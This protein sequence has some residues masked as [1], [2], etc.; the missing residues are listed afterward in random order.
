L[1]R[2]STNSHPGTAGSGT[3]VR[4]SP[5]EKLLYSR[6]DAAEALSISLRMIDYAL[7][8]GEFET[9]YNGSRR[10]ITSGSLKRW[11]AKDHFGAVN[12]KKKDREKSE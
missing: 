6:Q 1:R 9:K 2:K 7:A 10:L 8:R 12:R 11:A 3:P 5:V 4:K